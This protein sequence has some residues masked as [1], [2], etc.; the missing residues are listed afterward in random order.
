MAPRIDD[1]VHTFAEHGLYDG[2]FLLRDEETGTY[3]DHMT[4]DAVYGPLVGSSL[5]VGNLL[6]TTVAQALAQD[7]DTRVAL[8][9]RALR[10]DEQMTL[11]GLLSSVG[12]RL[13]RMF[14]STV[15]QEDDRLPTMDLGVGLWQGDVSRYYP[16]DRVVSE[17]KAVLDSFEGRRVLVYLD[18]AAFALGAIYVE[19]DGFEWD[20]DVLR[21]SD[22]TYIEGG[23]LRDAGGQRAEMER[24]LQVFTR[25][26]GFSLTF[27]GTEIYGGGG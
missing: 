5:E 6:Q 22:G 12:G 19:A 11:G 21:L 16:Y 9:D 27:P 20:D 1:A 26:Y 24:P 17:G 10:S 8:S 18:P 25:W 4:G 2:L 13:S 15:E 14:S 3:W 7:P 23:V